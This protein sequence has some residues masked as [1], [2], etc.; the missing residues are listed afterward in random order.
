MFGKTW[1]YVSR[2]IA[3]LAWPSISETIFGF[4]FFLHTP[5]KNPP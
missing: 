5:A 3:M 1:E 2:V 4:T